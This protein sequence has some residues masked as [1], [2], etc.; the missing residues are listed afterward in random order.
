VRPLAQLDAASIAA[1]LPRKDRQ[2]APRLPPLWV[3]AVSHSTIGAKGPADA[4][5]R[6]PNEGV[7]PANPLSE[8]HVSSSTAATTAK[9]KKFNI[10]I[11]DHK[12]V[13]DEDE[14]TG[15][16]LKTLSGIA[17]TNQL[18]LESHGHD[19]D[20]PIRDDEEIELKSGMKFYDVPVGNLGAR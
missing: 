6:I 9:A 1:L 7:R 11:N 12:Y 14:M 13:V 17:S 2:F 20:L 10:F 16:Q 15:A 18:F 8:V 5:H 4:C 19:D 3:Q